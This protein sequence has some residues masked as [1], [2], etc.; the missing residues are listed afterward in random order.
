MRGATIFGLTFIGLGVAALLA[1]LGCAASPWY[2][3]GGIVGLINDAQGE[4]LLILCIRRPLLFLVWS[5]L[6]SVW[7]GFWLA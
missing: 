3:E 4:P 5:C 1:G 7:L 2:I 6:L